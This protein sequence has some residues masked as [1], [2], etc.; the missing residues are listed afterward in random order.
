MI[1][2]ATKA[3][4]LERLTGRLKTA[5]VLPG[6][7]TAV[8]RWR[9]M[10]EAV[11]DEVA[12]QPW[13]GGPLI[14]RSS[15]ADEDGAGSSQAGR[16]TSV[17]GVSGTED[18]RQ[19]IDAV[20]ASYGVGADGDRVLVQPLLE[21]V[22]ISGVA[23]S[24]DPNTGAPYIVISYSN[25]AG[26]TTSVTA[27]DSNNVETVYYWRDGTGPC[28]DSLD[29]VVALVREVRALAGDQPVDLE[30]ARTQAGTLVLLQARSL[31]LTCPPV[32]PAEH[33]TSLETIAAR[34]DQAARPHPFLHG[35]RTIFGVMP[36][37][38]PAEIIGIRPRPLALSLYRDLITD[39]TW[40]YQRS[41]YGYKNL[42]SHPLMISFHGLPYIDVRVSFNSF[43][44]A[45][46]SDDLAG[47]LANYYLGRLAHAPELHD[48]IEFDIIFSCYTL[49]LDSRLESL[50][51]HG[52][53]T[54]DLHDLT[55]SLRQL[56]NRIYRHDTGL[57]RG[58]LDRLRTLK[59]RHQTLLSSDLD[60]ASRIYWL[61]EDCKRHG[62]LPFAGLA[63]A[64][65]I[66]V[67][68]LRSL[69]NIGVFSQADMTAFMGSLETV[70][71]RMTRDLTTLSQQPFLT[72][73]GHLRPGTYDI[74]SPRYDEAPNLYFDWTDAPLSATPPQRDPPF[75]LTLP[76]MSEISRL[77]VHHKLEND[78]VGLF[79]FLKASIEGREYAKFLFTRNLSDALSLF[80]D[81]GAALGFSRDDL[82][83]ADIRIVR[84]MASSTQSPRDLLAR[85]IEAGQNAYVA[86]SRIVL[87]PLL[88]SANDVWAFRMPATEPNFITQKRAT[89]PVRRPSDRDLEGAIVVIPSADP[90]FD[91]LFSHRIAGFITAYGGVNSHMAIRAGELGLPAVIGAGEV[92]Y[93]RWSKAEMLDVDCGNRQVTVLR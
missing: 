4:T 80:G 93:S 36:D 92:L 61:L 17:L 20:A 54:Q 66:A 82:S 26:D 84:E 81:L 16:Y 30:F 1:P 85:S 5:Q 31:L 89:A 42:R 90:G 33:R 35:D 44:P 24:D 83:Y 74:L 7:H 53:S 88:L 2:F 45:G 32:A 56:T 3:E 12:A 37:W 86:T 39:L 9:A 73:Y 91:W 58:D 55:D 25:R 72:R 76:Q 71:G 60:P 43:I 57:W 14:V 27:G 77:L 8:T 65:F 79:E 52:F 50:R 13:G 59:A 69:V 21:D 34:L 68:F 41:N 29:D 47:R 10:P 63:R 40:A 51:D 11:L 46:A 18:L 6:V 19:A 75:A 22:T 67:Q 48:K 38:N 87:P 62:T 70:S 28:P 23:F 49:D 15:A 64:G 78:I